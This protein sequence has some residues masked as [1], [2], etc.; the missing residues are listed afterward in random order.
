MPVCMYSANQQEEKRREA[1]REEGGEERAAGRPVS[2]ST[3]FGSGR[4]HT[5]D[6]LAGLQLP[7]S[8]Y[9]ELKSN[10]TVQICSNLERSAWNR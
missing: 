10:Q 7:D 8:T 9:L 4:T 2:R 1:R 5:Q 3:R 6:I